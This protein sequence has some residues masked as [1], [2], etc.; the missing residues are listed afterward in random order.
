MLNVGED[1][2]KRRVKLNKKHVLTIKQR[3]HTAINTAATSIN[4]EIYYKRKRGCQKLNV[5]KLVS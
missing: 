3:C 1:I 5:D 2:P 4:G